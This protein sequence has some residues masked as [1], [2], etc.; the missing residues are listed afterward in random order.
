MNFNCLDIDS[1]LEF[2]SSPSELSL[3]M[4][5]GTIAAATPI[6]SP[7]ANFD[8]PTFPSASINVADD[9]PDVAGASSTNQGNF[10]A[11]EIY[12]DFYSTVD[13]SKVRRVISCHCYTFM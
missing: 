6:A 7:D 5:S 9:V 10:H 1:F 12:S 4:A 11:H 3:Q 13:Y 8:D 2:L